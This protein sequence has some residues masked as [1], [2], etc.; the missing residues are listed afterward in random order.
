MRIGMETSKHIRS[1]AGGASED[2]ERLLT[3]LENHPNDIQELIAALTCDQRQV[4]AGAAAVLVML[5]G[6]SPALLEPFIHRLFRIAGGSEHQAVRLG[7]AEALPKL[8][9]GSGQAGRL[10]FVFE[11]WLDDRDPEIKRAAMTALVALVP[12][13]PSLG[14]RI[15]REIERRAGEGSP[16]AINHGLKLLEGLR[17]F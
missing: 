14:P 13:R 2:H 9:L 17:E 7:I 6:Q 5:A 1:L 11:S 15:R 3:H 16:T 10:A 12:Q 4:E 8:A